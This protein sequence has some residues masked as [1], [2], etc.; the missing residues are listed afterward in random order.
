MLCAAAYH[1]GLA[2]SS[3]C[4]IPATAPAAQGLGTALHDAALAGRDD[5]VAELIAGGSDVNAAG[6]LGARPLHLAAP[7]HHWRAGRKRTQWMRATIPPCTGR[8]RRAPPV[9]CSSCWRRGRTCASS[10]QLAGRPSTWL[11]RA[12]TSTLHGSCWTPAR[13]QVNQGDADEMT[14]IYIAACWGQLEA[15][16]LLL[17][18]GADVR[19]AAADGCTPLHTAARRG[20]DHVTL[21]YIN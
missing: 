14:P 8:A 9:S 12:G 19:A 20:K 21:H 15:A 6:W 2:D 3:D 17:E 13:R 18:R 16:Q 7:S 5:E 10:A 4:I 11:C 1:C